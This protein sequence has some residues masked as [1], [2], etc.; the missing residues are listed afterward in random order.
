[1]KKLI[2]CLM[3]VLTLVSCSFEAQDLSEVRFKDIVNNFEEYKEQLNKLDELEFE[4]NINEYDKKELTVTD[5]KTKYIY[6]PYGTCSMYDEIYFEEIDEYDS[7]IIE[8]RKKVIDILLGGANDI[9]EI[10]V[11][12]Y[13]Y[14]DKN[15][16][17]N[18]NHESVGCR[19]IRNKFDDP[20]PHGAELQI[21]A[22]LYNDRLKKYVSNEDLKHYCDRAEEIYDLII[23]AAN[24]DKSSL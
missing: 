1:M 5:S 6:S 2:I 23:D 17:Y 18:S 11:H 15:N 19:Y 14:T 12:L 16:N 22:D 4:T 10:W 21:D 8:K 3:F 9:N 24:T 7:S 20:I 13:V